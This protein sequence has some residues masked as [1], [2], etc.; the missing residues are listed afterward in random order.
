[1]L[2][3]Y[4]IP[5]VDADMASRLFNVFDRNG[6][7]E[8]SFEEF[9][10][11]LCGEM[12]EVRKRLVRE[13][14]AKLD[15][16]GSG[17]LEMSEVKDHFD[18]TRHPDVISGVKTVEEAR[19]SFFDMFTT[20]HNASTGFSGD[21]S[22]SLEEFLEYHLYLNES[23][24]TDAEFRNF[25]IGVWNMDIKAIPKDMAG[26]PKTAEKM[27]KNSREH[28][29]MENHKSLFGQ[30]TIVAHDG[31]S[32]AGESTEGGENPALMKVA[33]GTSWNVGQTKGVQVMGDMAERKM[34][35]AQQSKGVFTY[36]SDEELLNRVRERIK[37]RGPRGISSL[38]KSFAIMDDDQSGT[39][40]IKEFTKA[41]T[42]YRIAT[43]PKEIETIFNHFDPNHDG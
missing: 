41:L 38:G 33:G 26:R 1:M 10:S 4:K 17:T 8:I 13:A 25:I 2:D 11:A 6:D 9:M 14:F 23:F 3:N 40:D 37:A 36:V 15:A 34:K 16:N 19:F 12:S 7:G 21:N 39:L 42:S 5:G 27:A 30:K 18:P 43:D 29:K 24:E 35:A 22:I 20:F 32:E 31:Q 28:W